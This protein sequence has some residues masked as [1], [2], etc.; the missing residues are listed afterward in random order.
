MTGR[1]DPDFDLFAAD[2]GKDDE[3]AMRTLDDVRCNFLFQDSVG[4]GG[5]I[6][7]AQLEPKTVAIQDFC[8]VGRMP[9]QGERPDLDFEIEA[10]EV[11]RQVAVAIE[12]QD[13]DYY[14]YEIYL[15]FEIEDA[16]LDGEALEDYHDPALWELNEDETIN[17]R[18][19]AV[20]KAAAAAAIA[21]WAG[22]YHSLGLI[23]A[24]RVNASR[25]GKCNDGF[26]GPKFLVLYHAADADLRPETLGGFT[27]VTVNLAAPRG[28]V[29]TL[30]AEALPT[31]ATMLY[32]AMRQGSSA[33][34]QWGGDATPDGFPLPDESREKWLGRVCLPRDRLARLV[35]RWI[36]CGRKT[37]MFRAFGD[38]TERE[39]GI[40]P[41]D[42]LVKGV[43]ARGVLT[44]LAGDGSAG[45]T[46][47]VH[48]WL[49][50]LGGVALARPR[51][52]LGVEVTGHA[53]CAVIY[54]EGAA[55]MDAYRTEC[56]AKVWG[57][58]TFA[59]FK[60]TRESLPSI[61]AGLHSFP[62]LDLLVIDP[63]RPFLKGD[64][65]SS[66]VVNEFYLPLEQFAEEMNCAVVITQHV[67][68]SGMS[69]KSVHDARLAVLGSTAVINRPRMVIAMDRRGNGGT[70]RLAPVKH[71]FAEDLLWVRSTDWSVWRHDRETH[72]L[73][74][75]EGVA[76]TSARGGIDL[77]LVFDAIAKQNLANRVVRQTGRHELFEQKLVQLTGASRRSIRAGVAALIQAS[78]VTDGPNGLLA[79]PG[80]PLVP[81]LE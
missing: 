30:S 75:A 11:E 60:G 41:T 17:S 38:A 66:D 55:G 8:E 29:L 7:A 57:R 56:H 9:P 77:D 69:G 10:R 36:T 26:A 62:V 16:S 24:D 47:L 52:I 37:D 76:R 28:A 51:T 64:E 73:L 50:S 44:L 32:E 15:R 65:K 45:K 5:I 33:V 23:R 48:E 42:W 18:M 49:S 40:K 78:R 13:I 68:K 63:M 20:I 71:N 39:T 79:L 74:P 53:V 21:P 81:S 59:E 22:H 54:G 2:I 61:L 12:A 25:P 43:L 80:N 58:S 6:A 31:N 3:H 46:S 27:P 14:A 34:G 70:V 1:E 19:I 35:E 72:T 67:S 4:V